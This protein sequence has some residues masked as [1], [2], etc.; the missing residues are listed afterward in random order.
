MASWREQPVELVVVEAGQAQVEAVELQVVELEPEEPLVPLGVLAGAVVHQP[1][2]RACA[3]VRPRAMCTGTSVSPSWRAASSRVWPARITI[4]SSTTI[5]CRQ[6]NSFS[7][8]ATVAM[9][10]LVPPRVAGVGDELLE[11]EFDDVHGPLG[12]QG[13][14]M[15]R[16]Y[17]RG[18]LSPE[19]FM[20]ALTIGYRPCVGRTR[21]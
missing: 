3:G 4:S 15:G 14:T 17:R 7:E 21:P 9:A 6:P 1:V 18:T 20:N 5:G 2:G 8:A 19:L 16:R 11:G 13:G 12:V 10:R